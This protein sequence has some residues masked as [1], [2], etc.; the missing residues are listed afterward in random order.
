MISNAILKLKDTIRQ[1]IFKGAR[2]QKT[3]PLAKGKQQMSLNECKTLQVLAYD[4]CEY[5]E[6]Y[7]PYIRL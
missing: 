1:T 2:S 3:Y 4:P 5:Q 6:S 7:I